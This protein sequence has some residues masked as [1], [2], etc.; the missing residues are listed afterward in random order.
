[1]ANNN[2]YS[3]FF[4]GIFFLLSD[5][6]TPVQWGLLDGQAKLKESWQ[7]GIIEL[8][9]LCMLFFLMLKLSPRITRTFGVPIVISLFVIQSFYIFQNVSKG[10]SSYNNVQNELN[11]FKKSNEQDRP[12][13]LPNVYHIVFDGYSSFM[14]ID[15]LKKLG[16]DVN[17]FDGFFFFKNNLSNYNT[18]DASLPSFYRNIIQQ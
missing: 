18:T 4:L 1:M 10:N 12:K 17:D 16:C 9:L 6:I 3:L 14:F 5:F 11:L 15:A 2:S 13:T 7:Q 8:L